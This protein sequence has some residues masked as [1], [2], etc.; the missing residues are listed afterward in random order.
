MN[1]PQS[2]S[3]P[4]L[5]HNNTDLTVFACYCAG[6]YERWLDVEELYLKAFELAPSRLSWRTRPDIPDYKKCARIFEVGDPQS[7]RNMQ[8]L[9]MKEGRYKCK[10][11]E[12]GFKWCQKYE[13]V[14]RN[15]YQENVVPAAATQ[16]SSRLIRYV[17][18]TDSFLKFKA[19]GKV[20]PQIW[21][22]AEALQCMIDSSLQVWMGRFDQL[23]ASAL[24]NGRQ[25]IE[26]F[27]RSARTIVTSELGA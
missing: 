5:T 12:E 17:E 21:Q 6:G 18:K 4:S 22:I 8:S 13:T 23:I 9:I 2:V 1:Q 10:L 20:D 19:D 26:S 15:L 11:S 16:D 14:L 27:A 25:D 24:I 3:P 7:S